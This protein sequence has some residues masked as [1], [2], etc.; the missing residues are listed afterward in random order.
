MLVVGRDKDDARSVFHPQQ[1]ARGFEAVHSRHVDIEQ[2]DIGAMADGSECLLAVL[3][4]GN[5]DMRKRRLQFLQQVAEPAAGRGFVVS[6]DD[7]K[8]A[9]RRSGASDNSG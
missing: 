1:M 2:Q 3:G 5:D 6:D 7:P 8:R 9:Y 4:L